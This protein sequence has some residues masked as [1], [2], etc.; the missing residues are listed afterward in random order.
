MKSVLFVC[1]GNTCRSPM[2]A[3]LLKHY[4]QEAGIEVRTAS[5]GLGA[6]TGDS[7]SEHALK[8]MSELGLDLSGHRSRKFHTA[9]AEEFDLILVMTEGHKRQLL[10]AAPELA[11]K[12]FLVQEY[13]RA[14][15]YREELQNGKEKVYEIADPFGQ[16]L[17]VYRQV[18]D[19]LAQAVQAIIAAWQREKGDNA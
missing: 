15:R 18:R 6:F 16:S 2:A 17:D 3:A 1:T 11:E 5:A 19:E 8:A 12:V 13:S 9:L 10:Q 7:A 4:A 14:A